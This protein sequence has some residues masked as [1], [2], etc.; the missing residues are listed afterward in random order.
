MTTPPPPLVLPEKC[1]RRASFARHFRL[2]PCVDFTLLTT[3][4]VQRA[5]RFRFL[6]IIKAV[7][8]QANEASAAAWLLLLLP[9]I[10]QEAVDVAM[11]T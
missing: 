9:C 6:F 3:A 4:S 8:A 7:F 10:S 11:V 2:V 1:H 5:A